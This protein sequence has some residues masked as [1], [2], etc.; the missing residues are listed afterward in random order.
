MISI[1]TP[2]LNPG[3]L[4]ERNLR[5]LVLQTA[6]FEHIVQDGGSSDSTADLVARYAG[7]YPVRFYQEKDSGIYDGVVRGM[8]KARGDILAWLGADDFYLPWTLSTVQQV[9]ARHPE[10]DWIIGIPTSGYNQNQVVKV[11]GLAP[12]YLRCLIRWGW[13]CSGRLGNLQ[14][15]SMFWRRSLWEKSE[16]PSILA[17]YKLAGDYHLWK[18]FA[19]HAQLWTVSSVL[20]VFSTSPTQASRRYMSKY[21]EEM[22]PHAHGARAAWWGKALRDIASV[23]GNHRVL[24]PEAGLAEGS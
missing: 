1:V 22:G 12:V 21:L 18:A 9:F 23:L 19:E 15:E 2:T 14:Q 10:V 17:G 20:A 13:C 7:Q 6:E 8:A 11:N 5:S 24:R 3:I 16:A 4:L